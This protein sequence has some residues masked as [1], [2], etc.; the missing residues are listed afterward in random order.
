MVSTASILFI[1][2]TLLVSL[3]FP[4][5]LGVVLYRK[6]HYSIR[7]LLVGV[8]VFLIFQIFTRIPA[9][10]IL[11][12]M[13]WYRKMAE[14]IWLIALFLGLTAGIFEE[15]GRWLGLRYFVKKQ[16]DT[17]NGVAFGIGHGGIESI[18]LVTMSMVNN[19]IISMMINSGTYDKLMN[20]QLGEASAALIKKT[21]LETPSYLFGVGG[22]ER[23]MT[24][25]IHI[26]LTLVV[27]E[28]VRRAKPLYL[29][30]A[31]LLHALLDFV[32]VM[33]SKLP[34]P[35][36]WAELWSLACAVA[37]V[38]YIRWMLQKRSEPAPLVVEADVNQA[39]E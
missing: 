31:I 36:L 29:L 5:I 30:Y 33:M 23:V 9:L 6:W 2:L 3:L 12:G 27:L 1:I 16:W 32:A 38:V 4:I 17:R 18:V 37:S 24:I 26:A 20:L 11:S 28:G 15:V 21:M 22:L 10:Q 19:L 8:L 7:A 14:N 25:L 39:A 34:N 13:S 35:I